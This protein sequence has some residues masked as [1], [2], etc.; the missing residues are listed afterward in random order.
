[1]NN[2]LNLP[3][4]SYSK[5]DLTPE[6]INLFTQMSTTKVP[7]VCSADII[8]AALDGRIDCTRYFN[9]LGYNN[10][11][12]KHGNMHERKKKNVVLNNSDLSEQCEDNMSKMDTYYI[13]ETDKVDIATKNM[14]VLLARKYI[15]DNY[16][17]LI[18]YHDI[19]IFLLLKLSLEGGIKA[20]ETLRS[21]CNSL[22]ELEDNV[23]TLLSGND[24][25]TVEWLNKCISERR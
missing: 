6:I 7:I 9:L 1:M 18:I 23:F 12:I 22:K 17:N 25:K 14:D 4:F 16:T 19:D 20:I 10:A 8:E 21:I 2:K 15:E 13:D 5:T 24:N 11:V 3:C